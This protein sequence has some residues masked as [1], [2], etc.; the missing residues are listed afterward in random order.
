M[1]NKQNNLNEQ[2]SD[3]KTEEVEDIFADIDPGEK[4]A[5]SARFPGMRRNGEKKDLNSQDKQLE[6]QELENNINKQHQDKKRSVI[7]KITIL[8]IVIFILAIISAAYYYF[9][10]KPQND[11]DNG[12]AEIVNII[13]RNQPAENGADKPIDSD[14]DGLTDEEEKILGTNPNFAD[15]DEDGLLDK[16]E[17]DTYRTD[18]LN[19]DTD[20]DGYGDGQEVKGG[21][22]P[23]GE[24]WN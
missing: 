9:F 2:Q 4:N 18:P 3:K 21:Y 6:A 13:N 11:K 14:F 8:M 19:P 12:G 23:L 17:I 15:S 7:K 5:A 16:E 20:E 1:F 10:Y 24:N 22:N